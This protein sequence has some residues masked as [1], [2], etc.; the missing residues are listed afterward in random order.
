MNVDRRTVVV[1]GLAAGAF[2]AG[3]RRV[4][5]AEPVRIGMIAPLSGNAEIVGARQ[6]L[7]V[8]IARDWVNANGGVM[9][10]ELEVVFVDSKGSPDKAV[11][12]ARELTGDGVKQIIG[13]SLS[14]TSIGVIGVIESLGGWR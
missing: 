7:G 1:G 12:A 4:R 14:A 13:P 9:G 5:A 11:A 6:K 10:R 3:A 2:A 8:E